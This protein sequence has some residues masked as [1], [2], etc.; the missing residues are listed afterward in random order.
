MLSLDSDGSLLMTPAKEVEGTFSTSL[1]TLQHE[2]IITPAGLVTRITVRL[3]VNGETGWQLT[4]DNGEIRCGG[5][6]FHAPAAPIRLLLDASVLEV[7]VGNREALTSR[8]Y[9][10]KH[11]T[12]SFHVQV[13]GGRAAMDSW[14][15]M[16]ISPDRLVS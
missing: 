8:V 14:A 7:F 4:D 16:P 1:D 11:G 3:D 5:I 15:L 13:E 9:T 12:T 10:V 2:W 6:D